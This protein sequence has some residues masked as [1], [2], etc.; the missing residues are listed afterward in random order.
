MGAGLV[1][2]GCSGSGVFVGV[3][4][5]VTVEVFEGVKV[6]VAENA[7]SGVSVTVAVKVVVNVA[8]G[9]RV[10]VRVAVGARGVLVGFFV[11]VGLRVG[12]ASRLLLCAAVDSVP[13]CTGN[14]SRQ[15]SKIV[16]TFQ[17]VVLCFSI[18]ISRPITQK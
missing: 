7:G 16:M 15:T 4:V 17:K 3:G 14:A 12:G 1:R 5:T 13:A 10:G 18:E 8:V 2:V 6:G 9:V 11:W